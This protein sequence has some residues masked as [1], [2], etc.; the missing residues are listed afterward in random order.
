MRS[1]AL[2]FLLGVAACAHGSAG[3]GKAAVSASSANI[4]AAVADANRPQA[5]RD[6]D[7]YR[8][9]A[10]M[11][12]FAEAKP[13]E[14]IG[15]LIPGAGYMTRLFSKAV[16]PAGRVYGIWPTE[17]E[18]DDAEDVGPYRRLAGSAPFR[19]VVMLEQPAAKLSAP[20]KVDLVFTAQNYHDYPDKFMGPADLAALNRQV[21]DALKPGGAYLVIDHVA[22]A[23]SGLR[24]TDTLHRIDPATVKAQV[25]KAGFRYVGESPVLRNPADTHKLNVFKKEIQGRTDQFVYL[26]RKPG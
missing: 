12:A 17:Y 11:L 6:L 14:R 4:V 23:G 19:N 20:E 9:P 16:G 8:K 24:D 22:D 25:V 10:E 15:E 5:D 3:D 26:F 13:G 21:F 7:M 2:V 18:K 1:L